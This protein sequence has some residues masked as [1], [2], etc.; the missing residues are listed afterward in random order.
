MRHRASAELATASGRLAPR[1]TMNREDVSGSGAMWQAV[2]AASIHLIKG[3]P[4]PMNL[5]R[6]LCR[7][8]GFMARWHQFQLNSHGLVL[9]LLAIH[10]YLSQC[11]AAHFEEDFSTDPMGHGWRAYGDE[12]L[13][14]WNE[15]NQ[16]LEVTW[17]STKPNSYFYHPLPT[18]LTQEDDFQ[19]GFDLRLQEI[20]VGLDSSK[21]FTFELALGLINLREATS[22]NFLRGTASQSPDL[23]EFDYFADSGFGATVSPVMASS[24]SQ[25]VPSFTFPLELT[26]GDLFQVEMKYV[27]SNQTLTT[28]LRRNGQPF[29]PVKDAKLG[30]SFA[31]FH[32]DTLA[33]CS[34]SD[35]GAGGSLLA[36]GVVDNLTAVLPDPP[37]IQLTGAWR[38]HV[39]Q[40]QFVGKSGWTYTLERSDSLSDWHAASAPRTGSDA[41]QSLQDLDSGSASDRAFYRVRAER[42]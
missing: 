27:S 35:R 18:A 20:Q 13:F 24:S 25:F 34:Y 33:V 4:F 39:W 22:A 2:L 16:D 9:V 3:F 1:L 7:P 10:L 41:P 17:D 38:E 29:G 30:S 19:F 15:S 11:T 23:V 32:V 37:I 31:G 21:P 8:T 26:V 40:A 42:K 36:Q 14:R 5:G 6:N 28:T 12:G